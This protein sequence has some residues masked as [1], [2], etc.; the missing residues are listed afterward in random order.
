[1]IQRYI[2]AVN[3]GT[4]RLQ[5]IA[6]HNAE[7]TGLAGKR[8]IIT[9]ATSGIGLA[10][11][12]RMAELGADVTLVARSAER[13]A[14]ASATIAAAARQRTPAVLIADLASQADVR[15]LA[16]DL[17]QRYPRID[18]LVN[19]AGAVYAT[20]RFSPDG[21]ELT[22]AVNHLAPFLLTT[23]LL[24]RIV[25][26]APARIITTAS[27]AHYGERI[28]FDDLQSL[29][30]YGRFGLTRYGETKL[31]N[32]LFTT[33]LARK[34]NGTGVTANCFHPGVV[35]TEFNRNNGLLMGLAMRLVHLFARSPERGAD[36]LVWLADSPEV[37][38]LSGGYFM[39]RRLIRPSQEA[40]DEAA[41]RRLWQVSEEQTRASAP[42]R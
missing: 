2:T 32:I 14:H 39:D 25:E 1:M 42:V 28:P 16:D 24:E 41:A 8:V 7:W 35:S 5:S 33:E 37:S 31:A 36:T 17:L 3:V 22:W 11:A 4:E 20:R 30:S 21:V 27:A 29:R 38:Q 12:R 13:A 10:A 18:V 9:G 15:R 19:N 34:L 6:M 26:S 40:R 23:L